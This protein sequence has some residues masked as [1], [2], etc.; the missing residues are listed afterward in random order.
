[1]LNYKIGDVVMIKNFDRKSAWDA[2]YVPTLR[3]VCLIGSRQVEDLDCMVRTRKIYVCNAHKIMPSDHIISSI[4]DK[5]VFGQK[6][7]YINDP[8]IIKEVAIIDTFLHE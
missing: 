6:G 3:V 4:L 2:K 1:M 8:R 7:K 5:Q